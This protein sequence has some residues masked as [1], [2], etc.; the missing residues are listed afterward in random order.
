MLQLG[1]HTEMWAP[2]AASEGRLGCPAAAVEMCGTVLAL[3][4][5]HSDEANTTF[6]DDPD[7]S[8][9]LM[10]ANPNSFRCVSAGPGIHEVICLH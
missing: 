1:Y 2:T 3:A 7:M 5:W 6:I 4:T 9:R 10:D 8:R